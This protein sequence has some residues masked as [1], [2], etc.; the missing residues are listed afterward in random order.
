MW[1]PVSCG[2]GERGTALKGHEIGCDGATY[3]SRKPD[4]VEWHPVN[5]QAQWVHTDGALIKGQGEQRLA[6]QSLA[7]AQGASLAS[8]ATHDERASPALA[9]HGAPLASG[10]RASPAQ[11]TAQHQ[12]PG[13][14]AEQ[15]SQSPAALLK[16][17]AS[18]A[19]SADPTKVKLTGKGE[20]GTSLRGHAI[21]YD[22]FAYWS[23]K[24]NDVD[25]STASVVEP[26]AHW[27]HDNGT[28]MRGQGERPRAKLPDAGPPAGDPG[29]APSQPPLQGAAKEPAAKPQRLTET[30]SPAAMVVEV[31]QGAPLTSGERASPAQ[32]TTQHQSPR[33]SAEQR[34][35]SPAALPKS[36]ALAARSADPTKVKQAGKGESGTSLKGHAIGYDGFAYW[37]LKS[38]DVDWSTASVVEPRAHWVHDNGTLM[39][40][41]GERPRAKLPDAGPPA[42]DPG[43]APSQPPLQGASNEP[44]P[45]RQRL[46]ETASPAAM[47]VEVQAT[48]PSCVPSPLA[49]AVHV[50]FVGKGDKGTALSGHTIGT[51]GARYVS[52]KTDADEWKEVG[53]RLHWM[54]SDGKPFRGQRRP[55]HV[56]DQTS[57]R[58]EIAATPELQTPP[59]K[60][61]ATLPTTVV[62]IG[63]GKSGTALR[64]CTIGFDGEKY[65]SRKSVDED[66]VEVGPS[67]FWEHDDGTPMRGQGEP[68]Q[69]QPTL[70]DAGTAELAAGAE[71]EPGTTIA[72]SPPA[73]KQ[74]IATAAAVEEATAAGAATR[75]A[76]DTPAAATQAPSSSTKTLMATALPTKVVKV[77]L[78]KSNTALHGCTIGFDGEKYW[79]R[80]SV[81]GD[82]VEVGP[83]PFWEHDD[84]TPM[85][86]QG[87][88]RQRQPKLPDKLPDTGTAELAAG[89]VEEPGTTIAPSPLA[90]KKIIATAAAV[91]EATAAGAATRDASDTPVAATQ[92]PSSGTKTLMATALPTKVVKVGL[93]KSGTALRGCTIGFDGEKYWSRKSV[94][95]DWVEV[96]PT[97]FWE[98]DDGT[99]MRGQG[100]PRQPT[101]KKLP[102]AGTAELPA[103][104]EEEPE[105]TVA[106][107]PR[108]GKQIIATA[109]AVEEAAAAGAATRDALDTPAAATG[110]TPVACATMGAVQYD[111][112]GALCPAITEKPP[113]P[114]KM[115]ATAESLH[116]HWLPPDGMASRYH[117]LIELRDHTANSHSVAITRT[118]HKVFEHLDA[119]RQYSCRVAYVE[120]G[121]SIRQLTQLVDGGR[122]PFSSKSSTYKIKKD[123]PSVDNDVRRAMWASFYFGGEGYEKVGLMIETPCLG[124]RA[125]KR[126]PVTML[127][128]LLDNVDAS[129]II[130]DSKGGPHG[131]NIEE[132]WNFMPLCRVCNR[133]DIKTHNA[134]DWF[135]EKGAATKDFLPL[136]EVLFRLWRG[137]KANVEN[138]TRLPARLCFP[139]MED[140]EFEGSDTPVVEF[141]HLYKFALELYSH[142]LL[143]FH[144]GRL[145]IDGAN[146]PLKRTSSDDGGGFSISKD[147]LQNAFNKLGTTPNNMFKRI[148][149]LDHQP[150]RV[151]AI[152]TRFGELLRK[153]KP[154]D[155]DKFFDY[156]K[157]CN[158]CITAMIDGLDAAERKL[159]GPS[160]R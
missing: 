29:D 64:G 68:R 67:P 9:A 13:Q 97:P 87:E 4:D 23:L 19:R 85:R 37:S 57:A 56:A 86:G 102:D 40:G 113:A 141:K 72:T 78:G 140:P 103:G 157:D 105:T 71:E 94:D 89:A 136:F 17:S 138:A 107:N 116:V 150:V 27:V 135:Y 99:P 51:D 108:A 52:R 25:W 96:G 16:S 120:K 26:R 137:R 144:G 74:I 149:F 112:A 73:G 82:W 43:D 152:A 3:L 33:Q 128:P 123:R 63:L 65:W 83:T 50:E 106:L 28:L 93:G 148:H 154:R 98:H 151:L 143:D 66:W 10:E 41:Q 59:Q 104:A 110:T 54:D 159:A 34:S 46:A 76:S 21:G 80:K 49:A 125:Q 12:S 70:P 122:G 61:M 88:P 111:E 8:R 121:A 130:A 133:D 160:P 142:G 69:Q 53:P 14:S 47:V 38:N 95:G 48:A 114:R 118:P 147:Q 60:L 145:R 35:Q 11:E 101:A 77:G 84:G 39:R 92:A 55:R 42:G 31:D 79:S 36:T 129:H 126:Q 146:Q 20:S 75:D 119:L 44:A 2:V 81:D 58:G 117:Y 100:E 30:A 24:S 91:E 5:S 155:F 7:A 131:E 124:C 45:K 115:S 109:A 62:K 22:G 1:P 158:A 139:E 15:R 18:A 90:G 127:R 156:E 6:K 132:T 32:E 153:I 134:I